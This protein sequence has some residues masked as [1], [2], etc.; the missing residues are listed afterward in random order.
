MYKI[1]KNIKCLLLHYGYL[2]IAKA[3]GWTL[4]T[5][6]TYKDIAKHKFISFH[7]ALPIQF[8]FVCSGFV[9]IL[10]SDA[11]LCFVHL[12]RPHKEFHV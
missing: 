5:Y 6:Y 12:L 10:E 4:V 9:K 2:L 3:Y 1:T 8:G 11:T 7:F